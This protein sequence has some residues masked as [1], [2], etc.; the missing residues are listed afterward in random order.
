MG[1]MKT[2][3]S[4]VAFRTALNAKLRSRAGAMNLPVNRV[5]TLAVMERFLARV[6]AVFPPTTV[7]KGGLALELRL[8][9]ARTTVDIDLRLLGDPRDA[10]ALIDAAA[11]HATEPSDFL[12][13]LAEPDP[14]HPTIRGEGAVYDG[15]RYK[16]TPSLAGERYGD[17]FGVD[18]SFADALHGE[19]V[20]VEGSDA[21]AF[22]GVA[23]VVARAYPPGSHLAEKLHAYTLPR[24]DGTENSR[25]KDLP[26]MALIATIPGLDAAELRAAI[27][28]TFTFRGTHAVPL[29]LPAPPP[30]WVDRYR[31]MADAESLAWKELPDVFAAVAGF[32]DPVLAGGVG[33]WD[34]SDWRWR[35]R[36]DA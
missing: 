21:F 19:P 6:V 29:V 13:F 16:V 20:E 1:G 24:R 31:N 17:V 5:R 26:D 2:Y 36:P 7:L 4:P 30:N 34:P 23:P 8:E 27:H 14:E 22:I 35:E 9:K 12:S 28:A 32:L 3:A 25:V 33:L 15:S 10:A 18:V 11:R